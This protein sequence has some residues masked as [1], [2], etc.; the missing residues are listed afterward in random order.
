MRYFEAYRNEHKV[1]CEGRFENGRM[2][3]IWRE[4]GVFYYDI[5]IYDAHSFRFIWVHIYHGLFLS[6]AVSCRDADLKI[7]GKGVY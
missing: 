5:E 7:Y 1:I 4:N 3:R 6:D 2:W